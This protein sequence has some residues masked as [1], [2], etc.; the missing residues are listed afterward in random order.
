MSS[1]LFLGPGGEQPWRDREME[2]MEGMGNDWDSEAM[3]MPPGGILEKGELRGSPAP[4]GSLGF[5]F[6]CPWLNVCPFPD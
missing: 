6:E 2:G 1:S 4:P 5:W 3:A